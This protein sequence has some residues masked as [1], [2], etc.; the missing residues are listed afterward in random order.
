VKVYEGKDIRN[1]GL[2]GHGHSGKTMLTSALLYTSGATNRLTRPDEGN[3]ITDFD[4][5][6][7]ARKIT[8]SSALAVAEWKKAK[9]NLIDTP[10]FNIFIQDTRAALV[11][12]DSALVVVD[13]VAGVEVQTE[14][15]FDFTGEFH[16]PT[17]FVINKLDR[18]RS[19]FERALASIQSV[20]GRGAIPLQLPIGSEK[21]FTGIVDLVTMKSYTYAPGGDGKGTEGEIPDD[22]Q[23]PAKAGHEALVEMVA[24]DDD[25]LMAEFFEMGTLPVEHIIE[26]MERE[27]RH[28]KLFPVL[29]TS[30]YHNIGSDLLLNFLVEHFPAPTEHAPLEGKAA[31]GEMITREVKDAAPLSAFVFKTIA[32]P[33]A[34]R[35]S[36]FKVCSGVLKNDEHLVD[37]RTG[38]DERFA[39]VGVLMGKSIQQVPELHAGDLGA[40]AKLRDTLT[41]DTLYAKNC[42]ISYPPVEMPEPSI[43]YAI[44]AKSRNDEDRMGNALHKILEEDQSLRFYRD[45]QTKEFL[46]AGSGQQHVEIIVSRLKK[47]YGV[48]VALHAPKIPYRE[49]IRGK[50]EVQG[51]HKKQ[52]GGHGQFGDCWI[53]MEPLPRGG[54]FEF[55]NAVFGG[56]IPKNFI[57]A[58]EK[59]ILETAATGFL[60][61]YPVVD[62]KVT[63]F[64]G[65]YHDVDSSEM[66]FKLAAR[67]AFK[68]AMQQA[69]P[70][71][72]E[73]VMTV[74][75]QAP[76]E[77]AGDLMGDMNGRRGRISGMDTK[78]GTQVIRAQVPMSE[79]LNY[80]NDLISMTQGRASFHMEFDHY[81]Y[82]PPLQAEKIIAAAKAARSGEEED[83]E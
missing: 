63:V 15:V 75:I 71:L 20:F 44:E 23:E 13:G 76:V 30:A 77:Y 5:E 3:T 26:G 64:D 28:R 17:A 65:S 21:N 56:A 70:S 83:E 54:K 61:G 45:P 33:F 39:H 10:G 41:G 27:I 53:R 79:M 67:K 12:S 9:I 73:P 42:Q 52:T 34:G 19:S 49:T 43:A 1:V 32:D 16:L 2:V 22:L 60:A 18:E 58:I 36:Y 47:R 59:G 55:A 78:N 82:V 6:E 51:R 24:E 7:V 50:A 81:D 31:G 40:V 68:L 62:F 35:V 48:D 4:E 11:A 57:P 74:E 72:L 80:Q 14:K 38:G 66:A 8:V 29:C 25:A 69:T 37:S 46:L